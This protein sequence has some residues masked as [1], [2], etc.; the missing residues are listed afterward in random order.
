MTDNNRKEQLTINIVWSYAFGLLILVPIIFL[1]GIPYYFI[2]NDGASVQNLPYIYNN[3]DFNSLGND[4]VIIIFIY[5]GIILHELIHGLT[6][7][8]FAKD[9]YKS[10]KYGMMWKTLTP[11]CH[12][13]EPLLKKN[14][15]LG[16]IMPAIILGLLPA[17]TAIIIGHVGMLLFGMFFTMAASGDFL[18]INLLRKE[19]GNSMVEDHP[20]EA[21]CYIYRY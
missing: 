10:I 6:W 17:V 2:W 5:G 11:Y 7:S 3:L 21:G 19:S 13:K 20:T 15:V 16:A 18:I 4:Y 1:Y 14:Y 8:I 12:C 9:G